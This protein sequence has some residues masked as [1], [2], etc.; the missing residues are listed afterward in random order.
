LL[1]DKRL[2]VILPTLTTRY[3]KEV[4]TMSAHEVFPD[5][6]LIIRTGKVFDKD[7]YATGD[8]INAVNQV[9]EHFDSQRGF[10]RSQCIYALQLMASEIKDSFIDN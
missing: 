8:F 3:R 2:S 7:C 10:L 1:T 4:E 6:T 9:I 5:T